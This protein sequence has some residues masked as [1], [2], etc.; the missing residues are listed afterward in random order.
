MAIPTHTTTVRNTV[1]AQTQKI[2]WRAKSNNVLRTTYAYRK[3]RGMPI[4]P[5][6]NEA[7]AAR[8]PGYDAEQKI[9]TGHNRNKSTTYW[10]AKSDKSLRATYAYRK[11]RGMPIEPELNEALAARFPGYDAEQKIFTYRNRKKLTTYWNAKSDKSL[12]ATYTVRKK[13]GKPIEPELNEALAARFPGYDAEQKIF[14]IDWNTKS[15]NVLRTTYA[16]RK[17]RDMPIEPELNEALAARFPGYD[18][19][20]QIFTYRNR[21]KSTTNWNVK[22]DHALRSL[23]SYRRIHSLP[24]E[25]ELQA[26]LIARFPGYD[27][28][29]QIFTGQARR[30]VNRRRKPIAREPVLVS[31][32]PKKVRV[33]SWDKKSDYDLHKAYI[34]RVRTVTAIEDELNTELARRFPDEYNPITRTFI[35]H[36]CTNQPK[37][38]VHTPSHHTQQNNHPGVAT[39]AAQAYMNIENT[40]HL[41][42]TVKQINKTSDTTYNNVYV[43][44]QLILRNHANTELKLFADNTLLGVHGIITTEQELP[45]QPLWLVYDTNL[46]VNKWA[47]NKK[48]NGYSIYVAN[49]LPTPTGVNLILSNRCM[50]L[51][52]N[53]RLKRRAGITRFEI[54]R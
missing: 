22:S 30:R 6:L 12:R 14:E 2:D 37:P 8:F 38:T 31:R 43:N 20:R 3:R 47:A 9:F 1:G 16:Y 29:R 13:C 49:V 54:Q 45:Q 32:A 24:I 35:T 27:A 34:K 23:Y 28:K 36:A 26:E 41:T 4:E 5:E 50:I 18:A 52:E 46:A 39:S 10:N 11:K 33:I 51:L 7:L 17:K 19:K 21:K 25:P 53:D 44:G 48:R 42:V 40:A 15:N